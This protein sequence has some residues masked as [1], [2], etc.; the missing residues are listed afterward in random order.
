MTMVISDAP[1]LKFW[2]ETETE[3][4]CSWQKTKNNF[5]ILLV[6]FKKVLSVS[7]GIRKGKSIKQ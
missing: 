2:A 4:V 7:I 5:T 3:N 1:K 6:Q